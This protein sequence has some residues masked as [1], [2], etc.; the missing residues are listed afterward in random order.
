MIWVLI[1]SPWILAFWIPLLSPVSHLLDLPLL[2]AHDVL[3]ELLYLWDLA[4]FGGHLSHLYSRLVVWDH[5]VYE[6]L[7]E[8]LLVRQLLRIHHH[9]HAPH[10]L[11]AHLHGHVRSPEL[12]LFDGLELL[13]LGLLARDDV[14]RELDYLLVLGVLER[15][16]GHR[17]S[18][19]VVGNHSIDESLVRIFAI[20]HDHLPGHVPGA[21]THRPVAHLAVVHLAVAA[22]ARVVTLLI[23][24]CAPAGS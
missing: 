6:R 22:T 11:L 15:D 18:A 14:P 3:C 23:T 20:L 16:L 21:H 12:F 24:P 13:Y 7:V 4:L 17:N 10:L 9:A 2:G 1:G 8:V 5:R 19:L